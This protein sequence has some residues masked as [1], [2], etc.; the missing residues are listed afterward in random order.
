MCGIMTA[1]LLRSSHRVTVTVTLRLLG[2]AVERLPSGLQL[3]AQAGPATS[4]ERAQ[5]CKTSR[6]SEPK[7]RHTLCLQP[8]NDRRH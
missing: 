2:G 5:V 3:G 4:D 8:P 6:N 1:Q 7:Q